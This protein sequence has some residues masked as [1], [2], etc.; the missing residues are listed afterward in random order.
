MDSYVTED[1]QVEAIKIWWKENGVSV[2]VGA[3][4]GLLLVFAVRTWNDRQAVKS[5][6]AAQIYQQIEMGLKKN[7]AI[8]VQQAEARLMEEYPSSVYTTLGALAEAA[9]LVGNGDSAGARGRLEW[10]ILQASD[11]HLK[12]LA[13]LRL[14]R[15]ILDEGNFARA[16]TLG[17]A[18]A[19]I[20]FQAE[21]NELRGDALRI[22]GNYEDARS[23]YQA[24]LVKLSPNSAMATNLRLKLDDLGQSPHG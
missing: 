13:Q 22:Q 18:A 19:T 23:A 21:A 24:A 15:L 11:P 7:Q 3:A 5:E 8:A 17:E 1:Q 2:F 16:L 14:G 10:T 4:L 12:A 20:G 6:A 9:V